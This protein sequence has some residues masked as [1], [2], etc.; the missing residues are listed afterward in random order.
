MKDDK[1]NSWREKIDPAFDDLI[2]VHL[3]NI[4]FTRICSTDTRKRYLS[5]DD[6]TLKALEY[7]GYQPLLKEFKPNSKNLKKLMN[8]AIIIGVGSGSMFILECFKNMDK[9]FNKNE[10][11]ESK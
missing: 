10:E 11:K 8:D 1:S 2:K 6:E 3:D 9:L 5:L 7:K 4:E